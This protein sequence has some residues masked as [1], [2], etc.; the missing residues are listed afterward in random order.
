MASMSPEVLAKCLTP[1]FELW[2][3]REAI[4]DLDLSLEAVTMQVREH[5]RGE[6]PLLFFLDSPAG[7]RVG[8]TRQLVPNDSVLKEA[9]VGHELQRAIHAASKRYRNAPPVVVDLSSTP[10]AML[11][12]D[13]L[14]E[15][16]ISADKKSFAAWKKDI[17]SFVKDAILNP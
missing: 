1:R 12:K 7:I 14:I 5:Q 6:E 17:A 15:D 16:S 4:A 10:N 9:V 13:I 2:D 3:S 11:W 8:D